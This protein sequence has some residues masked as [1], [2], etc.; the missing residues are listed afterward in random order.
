VPNLLS[1]SNPVYSA[2][3]NSIIDCQ[4]E[5]EG[6]SSPMP[7]TANP[8]DVEELGRVLY[9]DLVAGKYGA[10]GA[11]APP[12]AV[13]PKSITR[14]Q[15]AKELFAMSLIS[16]DE[17]VA[18][19]VSSTPPAMVAS[20]I[21]TLSPMDQIQAKIDF[22]RYEYDRDYPLLNQLMNAAGKTSTDVDNFFI[23]AAK[24]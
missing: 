7:F 22:A 14:P 2:A 15:A 9:T 8:N 24:L 6:F 5:L 1:V 21:D 10:I 12:A 16:P 17:A 4:I 18:M 19:A 23:A 13:V 3:D 20:F 11:Y